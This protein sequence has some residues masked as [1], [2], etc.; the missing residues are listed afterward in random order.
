MTI[1]TKIRFLAA[2]RTKV[3]ITRARRSRAGFIVEHPKDGRGCVQTP[4]RT[5]REALS[6]LLA[7]VRTT[8]PLRFAVKEAP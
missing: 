6:I 1:T 5:R 4:A 8:E 7:K 2:M 3:Q